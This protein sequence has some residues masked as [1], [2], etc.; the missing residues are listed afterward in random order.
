[1]TCLY[2]RDA[3]LAPHQRSG[4][5][6]LLGGVVAAHQRLP[7]HGRE[8][9]LL[10]QGRRNPPVGSTVG[11]QRSQQERRKVLQAAQRLQTQMA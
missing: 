10:V 2:E 1:M 11:Q 9:E 3:L 8:R 4:N 6:G 7:Q 5:G